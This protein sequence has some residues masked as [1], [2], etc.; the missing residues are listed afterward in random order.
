MPIPWLDRTP[1]KPSHPFISIQRT[2]FKRFSSSFMFT[3]RLNLRNP[4]I[5]LM[6]FHDLMESPHIL[7]HVGGAQRLSVDDKLPRDGSVKEWPHYLN[8]GWDINTGNFALSL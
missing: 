2:L 8:H 4:W 5:I 6:R 7:V 3:E 1:P